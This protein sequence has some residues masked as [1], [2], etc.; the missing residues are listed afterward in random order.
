[1]IALVDNLERYL[2]LTAFRQKL[3]SANVANVDTPGYRTR[4]VA[5]QAEL[6]RAMYWPGASTPSVHGVRGLITRPDGNDVN[7]DRETMLLAETQLQFRMGVQLLRG[8]FSRML[9][10]INE[11]KQS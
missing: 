7:I 6:Q 8:E 5:F 4:D 10:A 9:L 1:M 3:V 11:G 2:D